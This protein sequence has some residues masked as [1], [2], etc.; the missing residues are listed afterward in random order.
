M[1]FCWLVGQHC[2]PNSVGKIWQFFF[3]GQ[4]WP[5]PM[6]DRGLFLSAAPKNDVYIRHKTQNI[7]YKDLYFFYFFVRPT[8]K[9]SFSNLMTSS[10][11]SNPPP[12]SLPLTTAASI[13]W[14]LSIDLGKCIFMLYTITNREFRV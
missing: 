3:L 2:W 12:S 10:S 6:W 13:S 5:L 11:G 14:C 9:T 7:F 4:H 1:L 8:M